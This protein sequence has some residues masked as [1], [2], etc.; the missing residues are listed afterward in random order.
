MGNMDNKI[1][2]FSA[3]GRINRAKFWAMFLVAMGMLLI[4]VVLMAL[5][6]GDS[7][8]PS[9]IVV[10]IIPFFIC[11][12]WISIAAQVKRWHDQ[13]ITGWMIL[14]NVIPII[15]GL[16]ALYC[17]GINKG[18]P[19]PNKY[20]PDPLGSPSVTAP[21]QA[22]QQIDGG[23][24]ELVRNLEEYSSV[25]RMLVQSLESRSERRAINTYLQR[26]ADFD[27]GKML[28]QANIFQVTNIHYLERLQEVL[29]EINSSAN[30]AGKH[31]S[32]QSDLPPAIHI[33]VPNILLV[34]KSSLDHIGGRLKKPGG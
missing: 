4:P 1:K 22:E 28:I 15:G 12:A 2:P 6:W 10:I 30:S 8:E 24:E 16:Y 20:G 3:K 33:A 14:I 7:D 27:L 9:P 25:L 21:D 32:E 17:L 29:N 34:T 31:A 23:L 11:G 5:I 26:L 19:G 13:D 18:T